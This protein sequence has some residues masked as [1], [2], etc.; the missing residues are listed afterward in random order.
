MAIDSLLAG[1]PTPGLVEM[2]SKAYGCELP[3]STQKRFLQIYLINVRRSIL[4][5]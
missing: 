4:Q 5:T 2:A 3:D 1:K